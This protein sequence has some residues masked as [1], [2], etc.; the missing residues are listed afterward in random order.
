MEEEQQWESSR[1]PQKT[2][3][4]KLVE[5]SRWRYLKSAAP[6]Q[7]DRKAKTSSTRDTEQNRFKCE[8]YYCLKCVGT[9]SGI[10][11]GNEATTSCDKLIQQLNNL[12]LNSDN[13]HPLSDK[14]EQERNEKRET[15][16]ES[17]RAKGCFRGS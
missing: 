8:C 1:A 10:S 16:T 15:K 2:R 17:K 6:Y 11:P 12:K 3:G 9:T 4:K 13:T 14:R 7:T 5:R